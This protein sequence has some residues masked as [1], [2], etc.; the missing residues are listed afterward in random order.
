MPTHGISHGAH[1]GLCLP[2]DGLSHDGWSCLCMPTDGASRGSDPG[3]PKLFC[4]GSGSISSLC[5]ALL[6]AQGSN[7]S[8]FGVVAPSAPPASLTLVVP[9]VGA[10]VPFTSNDTPP[11][12]CTSTT[13]C[14]MAFAPMFPAMWTGL[15]PTPPAL[16]RGLH[17]N[18]VTLRLQDKVRQC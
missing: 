5:H 14:S 6:S 11:S 15:R 9:L 17:T 3:S 8:G 13:T 4:G 1:C 16:S 7:T 10:G 2:S 12:S 18:G